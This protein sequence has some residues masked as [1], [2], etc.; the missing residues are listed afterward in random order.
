MIE[1]VYAISL[2]ILFLL[3]LTSYFPF[4][5][6]EVMGNR[7]EINFFTSSY[8]LY[9]N[10]DFILS[11]TVILTTLVI[12]FLWSL[13]MV[14]VF[15]S[16]YHKK[17]PKCIIPLLKLQYI[18]SPWGMLDVYLVGVLVSIV[19]L[20]KMGTIIVGVSLWS[21]VVLVVLVAYIQSIY[22]PHIIWDIVEEELGVDSER[23]R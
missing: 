11:V 3:I 20:V 2:A 5:S 9:K 14:I 10:G 7:T 15:G 22:D 21:L 8:Y 6:F 16:I 12:P 23:D 1:R 4:L 13:V 18:L 19:K 17:I